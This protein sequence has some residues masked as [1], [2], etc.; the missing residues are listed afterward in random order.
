MTVSP[1]HSSGMQAVFGELA[2]DP[3]GVGVRLVDLVDRHDDRHLGRLRVVD[4]LPRLRHDAVVGRD[5]QDD[6]VGDLRA[7]GTHLRER[8]VAGRVEEHDLAGR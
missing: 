5:D 7:A 6:D 2:L 1:P 3:L 4:G 8:L